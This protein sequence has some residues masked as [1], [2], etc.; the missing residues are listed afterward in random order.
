[1]RYL[2]I[3]RDK[4]ARARLEAGVGKDPV[5]VHGDHQDPGIA[6]GVADVRYYLQATPIREAQVEQYRIR[7]KPAA[8]LGYL[9][10]RSEHPDDLEFRFQFEPE[11]FQH[12]V[13][14]ID[15][16]ESRLYGH[17]F[18][19]P[20]QGTWPGPWSRPQVERQSPRRLRRGKLAP[21][22]R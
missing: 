10:T 2:R 17:C 18:R 19:S 11:A 15:Q 1:L 13:V 6:V 16:K 7:L 4:P 12:E 20:P 9:D 21:E 3:F 8:M 14:I 22:S 5:T